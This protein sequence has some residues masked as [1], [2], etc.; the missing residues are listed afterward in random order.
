MLW[1]LQKKQTF[2]QFTALWFICLS[3]DF[4]RIILLTG[5]DTFDKIF[6]LVFV[7]HVYRFVVKN[8]AIHNIGVH[9]CL[10]RIQICWVLWE[11][12]F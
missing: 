10:H 5:S 11:N 1:K 7:T 4:L 6:T 12:M 9:F 2:N 3:L 8:C